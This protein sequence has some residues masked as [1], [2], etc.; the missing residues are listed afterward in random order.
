MRWSRWPW[1]PGTNDQAGGELIAGSAGEQRVTGRGEGEHQVSELV[2]AEELTAGAGDHGVSDR[3]G[4]HHVAWR[5]TETGGQDAA[6]PAVRHEVG[7][8]DDP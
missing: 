7:E 6:D 8:A 3:Q 2:G 1:C 4:R 5:A